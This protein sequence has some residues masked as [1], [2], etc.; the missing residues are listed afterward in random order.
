[1]STKDMVVEEE[2]TAQLLHQMMQKPLQNWDHVQQWKYN[3]QKS[4]IRLYFIKRR[5]LSL[6]FMENQ[7]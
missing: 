4:E 6:F 5:L 7:I 3:F 2:V 1:M